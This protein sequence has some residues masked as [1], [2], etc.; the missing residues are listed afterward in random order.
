MF[1]EDE[2]QLQHMPHYGDII[3]AEVLKPNTLKFVRVIK[4]ANLKRYEM[5]ISQKMAES[6]K[7]KEILSKVELEDGYWER[8][9]GGMLTIF[10]P[11]TS[12]FDPTEAISCFHE[13]AEKFEYD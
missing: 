1:I 7:Q 8:L 2:E 3:E 12:A 6:A 13:D 5:L 10:V 9:F 11:E 4:R